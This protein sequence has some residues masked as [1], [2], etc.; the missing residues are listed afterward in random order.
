MLKVMKKTGQQK[1]KKNQAAH[2]TLSLKL[3]FELK[4]VFLL[5]LFNG[6]RIQGA[7]Y[8]LTNHFINFIIIE[9][10][11]PCVHNLKYKCI[12]VKVHLFPI[13]NSKPHM[14]FT[15]TNLCLIHTQGN[16]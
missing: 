9:F 15:N 1:P 6:N 10:N 8:T 16:C 7:V 14:S 5:L 3:I 11:C 12:Y 2:L 13:Y 4:S